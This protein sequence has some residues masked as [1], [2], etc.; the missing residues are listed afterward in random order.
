MNLVFKPLRHVWKTLNDLKNVVIGFSLARGTASFGE[1]VAPGVA[2]LAAL[3]VAGRTTPPFVIFQPGGSWMSTC[4]AE[5]TFVAAGFE[6]PPQPA[7]ARTITSSKGGTRRALLPCV[8]IL[9]PMA[10]V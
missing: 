1:P 7:A 2:A 3:G 4:P 8:R 10:E 6:L 9:P 5:I